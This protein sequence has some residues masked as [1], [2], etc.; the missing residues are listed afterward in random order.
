MWSC[1]YTLS[2]PKDAGPLTFELSGGTGNGNLYV[3]FGSEPAH[4]SYV[5]RPQLAGSA[6][7]CT[8]PNPEAGTYYVKVYAASSAMNMR[9]KAGYSTHL[10]FGGMWGYVGENRLSPNPATGSDTCPAGYK[11]TRLL[12][13]AA[14]PGRD[15]DVFLCSRPH[16]EDR[17]PLYDFGGMWGY[18][19][20]T[21]VPNPYTFDTSCPAGY[22]EQWILGSYDDFDVA[23]CYKP[24]IPGTKPAFPFGG[25]MGQ[26]DGGKVVPNPETGTASCPPGFVSRPVSGFPNIDWTMQF[27]YQPPTR[28]DFGGMWGIVDGGVPVYNPATFSTTCPHGYKATKLLETHGVDWPVFVCLRPSL[29]GNHQAL[30][31]GGM[32]SRYPRN[33]PTTLK[34]NPY[35][36][37][38]SCP[39]GYAAT[40]VLGTPGVDANLYFCHKLNM[41]KSEPEY[42][43]GGMWGQVE[44]GTYVPNRATGAV[45]CPPGYTAKDML[46]INGLDYQLAFCSLRP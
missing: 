13:S 29:G 34:N 28:W 9:L 32:Y 19:L 36:G 5:C 14:R 20:G 46:G 18:V 26:V 21:P 22:T 16:L 37:G 44:G 17:E 7:T 35:T 40:Q 38:Q 11:P 33:A 3:Q 31:F 1:T 45:S 27:C 24:H 12:G 15:L 39:P 43:F 6:E 41:S 23:V 8:I 30:D 10:D 4:N 42:P 25:M 2:V